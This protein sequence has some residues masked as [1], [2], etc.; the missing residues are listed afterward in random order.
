V[1]CYVGALLES[2]LQQPVDQADD[3]PIIGIRFFKIHA[4]EEKR[5]YRNL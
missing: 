2:E 5:K 4:R 3:M 1:I